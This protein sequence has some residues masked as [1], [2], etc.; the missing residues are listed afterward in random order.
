MKRATEA[1]NRRRKGDKGDLRAAGL[2]EGTGPPFPQAIGKVAEARK[3]QLFRASTGV[4]DGW[5]ASEKLLGDP[6]VVSQIGP[7]GRELD[8]NAVS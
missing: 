6:P 8:N 1:L 4:E 2:G 3:D 7:T 5:G